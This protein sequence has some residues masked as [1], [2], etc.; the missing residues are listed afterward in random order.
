MSVELYKSIKVKCIKL[1]DTSGY[2]HNSNGF[3][4][5][6][7]YL[8]SRNNGLREN[9]LHQ[10]GKTCTEGGGGGGGALLLTINSTME[11]TYMGT[12]PWNRIPK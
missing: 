8:I 2:R 5:N 1:I 6:L 4:E 7:I 3:Y 12:C 11:V 9:K 10:L